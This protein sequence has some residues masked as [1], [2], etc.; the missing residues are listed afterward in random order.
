MSR[1]IHRS[2]APGSGGVLASRASAGQK[3]LSAQGVKPGGRG[4][5]AGIRP[6]GID[7]MTARA[8]G[9]VPGGQAEVGEDF[10]NDRGMFDGDDDLQ[11]AAPMGAVFQVDL[12]HPL[13]QT[14]P[15]QAGRRRGW[16][17]LGGIE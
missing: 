7:R 17:R 6:F 1:A 15:A 4:S 16:G 2:E 9:A 14:G 10:G 8:I 3:R 12:E 11:E 5:R 13:E